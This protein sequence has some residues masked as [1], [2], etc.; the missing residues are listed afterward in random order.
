MTAPDLFEIALT[1]SS[2][3]HERG[4]ENN[5]RL[6]FLGD[7]V[8][9]LCVS[10]LLHHEHPDNREG[11]L[12]KLRAALVNERTLA[13]VAREMKLVLRVGAGRDQ[14]KLREQDGPLADAFEAWLAAVYLTEGL[15]AARRL[16]R[17]RVLPHRDDPKPMVDAKSELQMWSQVHR[18]GSVPQYE[19]VDQEGP[20]HLPVF[21]VHVSVDGELL[22][23]GTGRSK[24]LAEQAAA[25]EVLRDLGLRA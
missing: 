19:L 23:R 2:Y 10:E 3:T 22:G 16:V 12:S 13:T 11:A 6:E 25:E 5:E 4:G 18:G 24:K 15:D 17:E 9:Q 14:A 1:H 21:T 20:D 8:L 7:A